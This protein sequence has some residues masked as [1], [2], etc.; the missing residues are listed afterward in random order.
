MD[1]RAHPL[2]GVFKRTGQN[3]TDVG[4]VEQ[5]ERNA[6]QGVENGG[7]LAPARFRRQI[8]VA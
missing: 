4:H 8:S 7:Q 3:I 2:V 6:G 5:H 1:L